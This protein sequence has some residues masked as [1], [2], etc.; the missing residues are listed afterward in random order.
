MLSKMRRRNRCN[1]A[2]AG[3][4]TSEKQAINKPE[5]D[6]RELFVLGLEPAAEDRTTA[7]T[8]HRLQ[9][10]ADSHAEAIAK[11]GAMRGGR[12]QNGSSARLATAGGLTCRTGQF[13][14]KCHCQ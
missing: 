12:N 5:Q 6:P 9:I 7:S 2:R 4:E 11:A 1:A 10:V 13:I 14:R 8:E 3:N